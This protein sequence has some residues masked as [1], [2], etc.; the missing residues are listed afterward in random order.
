MITPGE[1]LPPLP[2]VPHVINVLRGNAIVTN[3]REQIQLYGEGSP[4]GRY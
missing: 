1:R 2:N 4:L 3:A